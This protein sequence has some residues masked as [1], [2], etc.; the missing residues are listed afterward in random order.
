[1]WCGVFVEGSDNI[2]GGDQSP[3][4]DDICSE[5]SV[6]WRTR[7]RDG[8]QSQQQLQDFA[9]ARVWFAHGKEGQCN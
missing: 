6:I 3:S 8:K 4:W 5:A 9:A 1:M 7:D 2:D